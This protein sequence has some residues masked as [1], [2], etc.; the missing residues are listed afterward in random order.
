MKTGIM[1]GIGILLGGYAGW[2][3]GV[4]QER[5]PRYD[6]QVSSARG[7]PMVFKVDRDTGEVFRSIAGMQFERVKEAGELDLRPVAS[8]PAGFV[9]E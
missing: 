4:N 3:V 8:V 9:L 7:Y 1:L 2:W 5:E 6:V